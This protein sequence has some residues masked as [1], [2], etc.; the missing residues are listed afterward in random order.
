MAAVAVV[1][2]LEDRTIFTP[3]GGRPLEPSPPGLHHAPQEESAETDQQLIP[4]RRRGSPASTGGEVRHK[5]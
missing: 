5:K 2:A 1:A 3:D 4:P